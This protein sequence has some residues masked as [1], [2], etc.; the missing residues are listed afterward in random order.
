K[1]G[2]LR[3]GRR[4]VYPERSVLQQQL[5]ERHVR[6]RYHGAGN[7]WHLPVGPITLPGA[8]APWDDPGAGAVTR[9]AAYDGDHRPA[10]RSP[11][12]SNIQNGREGL[13]GELL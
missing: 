4:V 2:D 11:R 13:L 10:R 5:R 8:E 7:G 3:S 9:G 12:R 6:G 1:R